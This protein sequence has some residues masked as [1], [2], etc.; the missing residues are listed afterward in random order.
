MRTTYSNFL[1]LACVSSICAVVAWLILPNAI[2][3]QTIAETTN[4]EQKKTT[5]AEA[6]EAHPQFTQDVNASKDSGHE[7]RPDSAP[8]LAVP[9]TTPPSTVVRDSGVDDS[10]AKKHGIPSTEALAIYARMTGEALRIRVAEGDVIAQILQ[11]GSLLGSDV[12]QEQGQRT[13]MKAAADGSLFALHEL[14]I[15]SGPDVRGGSIE[16]RYAYWQVALALG[17]LGMAPFLARDSAQMSPEQ[18]MTAQVLFSSTF[19]QL[20]ELSFARNGRGLRANLRP[21]QMQPRRQT[22]IQKPGP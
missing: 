6:S 14:A 8:V 17:D 7:D 16:Q 1:W 18:M 3:D 5:I 2:K 22:C 9:S 19:F 4:R 15:R 21:L 11:A 20:S 13:L 10:W 12:T